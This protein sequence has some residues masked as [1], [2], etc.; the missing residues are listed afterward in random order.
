VNS[1]GL[2]G[3]ANHLWQSTLFAVAVASL[4]LL[5]RKNSARIRYFL[6]LAASAKFLVPFALLIAVGAKIPWP[7]A[8]IRGATPT[9]FSIAT[10]K[11]TEVMQFGGAG[12][13][14]LTQASHAANYSDDVLIAVELIW[15]L[16]TLVVVAHWFI[17]WRL[18]RRA[19]REST[20]TSL[21]F[22]IPV[23]LSTAQLEPAVVGIRRPVLLLPRGI[24]QRLTPDE[25]R[26]VLAHERCHVTWRDNLTAT[27]HMIV[28]GLFWFHPLIWWLGMRIVDERERACDEQVLAEGHAPDSYAEGI[29]KVCEHYLEARIACVSGIGGASLRLR[30]EVIAK[31]RSIERL[32]TLRKLA[33]TL[34]ACATV[35]I[36][37]GVGV[38]TAP[39]AR[40]QAKNPGTDE[41]DY[42]DVSIRSKRTVGTNASKV[43][44]ELS[45]I[46]RDYDGLRS[47]IA[48]AY[49]IGD[50]QIVGWDWSKE[51]GYDIT[52]EDPKLLP[53]SGQNAIMRDLLAKH[54]GLVVRPARKR[55][56]GYVLLIGSSGSKL[57]SNGTGPTS[58]M[59]FQISVD[60]VE[61]VNWPLDTLVTYLSNRVFRAPVV[62]QT[63]LKG[64][65]DYKVT[66]KQSSPDAP[67]DPTAMVKALEEQLG[68]RL[69]SKS[70]IVDV[71]NVVSV[72]SPAEVAS[73]G[74]RSFNRKGT[75]R[76]RNAI[77][78]VAER[79]NELSSD[80]QPLVDLDAAIRQPQAPF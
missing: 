9:L 29:L 33:I 39:H 47:F 1:P 69:E 22:V 51:P 30:I 56:D 79:Q 7:V 19:R 53:P 17:R 75:D 37:V 45:G 24:E 55:M 5:L 80:S 64:T 18:V 60:R 46:Q 78:E 54:F 77:D 38:F 65:Y 36:P 71:I 68:L 66:W 21:A 50:S 20:Q 23:R 13:T 6:W 70:L 59:H 34:A 72:K 67:P 58:F 48:D 2:I 27:F 32:S 14:S 41:P 15:A 74:A 31:N 42:R 11:V 44:F 40:A 61:A 35:A 63:G 43:R 76:M 4:A 52:A 73:A 3:L 28:E 62:D 10:A 12:A 25:I 26:A 57:K 16:G 8:A 49:R